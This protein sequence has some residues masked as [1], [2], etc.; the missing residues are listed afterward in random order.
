MHCAFKE[1][2]V[3]CEALGGGLQSVIVRKGGIAEGR[4]GFS[5]R[6]TEFFLFPTWFH[7]QVGKT[8]LPDDT[9]LPPEPDGEIE[10]RYAATVEWSGLVEDWE[11]VRALA[12]LHIL[13][14]SVIEERFRQE[15]RPGVH[16]AFV[17]IY[18]MDPPCRL[19]IEKR[20]GGCRSWIDLPAIEECA[21][22]SVISDEEHARRKQALATALGMEIFQ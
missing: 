9:R 15:D 6:E 12:D 2:A 1:W 21:M 18:R 20:F 19:K 4:A 13:R 11:R 8:R 10:I 17:R 7:E 5:F 3:V 14:E 22:V 16:V